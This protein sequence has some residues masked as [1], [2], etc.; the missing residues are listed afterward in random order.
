MGAKVSIIV[1]V[2]NVAQYIEQCVRSLFGQTL[3]DL[4]YI[5][6]DDKS[7]DG[8]MDIVRKVLS[9]YPNREEQVRIIV[10]EE[11]SS[12]AAQ[13]RHVE[14][15]WRPVGDGLPSLSHPGQRLT[16]G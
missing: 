16:S 5:F 14:K 3:A 6:V 7:C 12:S 15:A 11:N 2:Y 10:H 8:S 4:E 13:R 9:E 1:A